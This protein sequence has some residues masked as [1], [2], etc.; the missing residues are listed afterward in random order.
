MLKVPLTAVGHPWL[1]PLCQ[2]RA[3]AGLN[4]DGVSWR[5]GQ[6]RGALHILKSRPWKM[7]IAAHCPW[8]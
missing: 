1:G 8:R 7:L 6:V 4:G 5:G 2:V 3:A